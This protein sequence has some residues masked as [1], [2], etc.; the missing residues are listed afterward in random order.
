MQPKRRAECLIRW[1]G[2]RTVHSTDAESPI[3]RNAAD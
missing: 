2:V 1:Q 3:R